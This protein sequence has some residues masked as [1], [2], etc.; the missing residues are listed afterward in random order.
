MRQTALNSLNISLVAGLVVIFLMSLMIGPAGIG[1]PEIATETILLEI[2]LPRAVIAMLVGGSLG[3]AGAAMQGLLRNPLAEPGVI[4]VS[5]TAGLGAVLVFYTGLSREFAQTGG[6][7][8]APVT[9]G[10]PS[11]GCII[12]ASSTG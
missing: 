6:T 3:L 8:S 9:A 7:Q 4:G 1:L 11:M 12:M 10:S 5:G 2:R